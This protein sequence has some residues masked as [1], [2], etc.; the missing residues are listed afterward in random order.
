MD[1]VGRDN[2]G[3]YKKM[4]FELIALSGD[5]PYIRCACMA[6]RRVATI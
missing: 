2:S 6:F 4:H 5:G 3:A 1:L